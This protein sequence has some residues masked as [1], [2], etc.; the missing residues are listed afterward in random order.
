MKRIIIIGAGPSGLMATISAKIHNED[1]EV[2]LLEKNNELGRK[3]KLTG[4]GRCNITA[5]VDLDTVID[6]VP[7]NAKFLYSCL[8][9]WGPKEIQNFFIKNGLELKIEDHYRVF[10]KSNKAEDVVLTLKKVIEEKKAIIKYNNNVIDIDFEKR[11]VKTDNND[12]H[13]SSLI[14]ATGGIILPQTGS[15]GDGHLFAKKIGHDITVL[16]PAEVPLVSNASFIQAKTLQGLTFKDV[17]VSLYAN[18]KLIKRLTHDLLV[19]HFGLSGPAALRLSFDALNQLE[20]KKEVILEIN[21]LDN[22]IANDD[23]KLIDNL[24]K[25]GIPKRLIQFIQQNAKTNKELLEQLAS[26]KIPINDTRGFNHAFVTNGGID[27]RQI[28]PKTLK[29][30]LDQNISFCGEV[31]DVNAYTGGYNITVAFSTGY[32]AGKYA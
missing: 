31:I 20:L 4:G 28:D 8:R 23:L 11:I 21:F 15:T 25:H 3:L 26:F 5:D 29:S 9:Q 24:V 13:Y 10:P 16:R 30:K 19:T 22:F 7:K 2:I 17:S 14:I 6:H 12:Y 1:A 18:N 27:L 32:V